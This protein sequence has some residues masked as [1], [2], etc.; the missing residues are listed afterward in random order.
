M[1]GLEAIPKI[2]ALL[3]DLIER[4][5]DSKTGALVSQLQS[6]FLALQASYFEAEQKVTQ[7]GRD[8]FATERELAAVKD[9]H[10]K[11]I[12]EL[13]A[14]IEKLKADHA[15]QIAR[16]TDDSGPTILYDSGLGG[17]SNLV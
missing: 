14:K 16:L 8:H 7:T 9:A 15:A 4:V 1:T 11:E 12:A 17:I 10:A 6:Q 13:Q 2:N 3:I 5:K